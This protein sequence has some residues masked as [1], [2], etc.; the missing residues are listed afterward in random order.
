MYKTEA[1]LGL[2][3]NI[4]GIIAIALMLIVGL[5]IGVIIGGLAATAAEYGVDASQ[6]TMDATASASIG[7]VILGLVLAIAS[8]VFGFIG[9]S[10]L[11]KEDKKGGI[12]LIIAG[13]LGVVSLFTGGW[14]GIAMIVLYLIGGIMAV[15]KK[16]APMAPPM[17]PPAA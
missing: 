15:T 13:G 6:V 12:F 9:T 17:A 5:V 16:A 14:Y 10:K 8:V 2:V 11:K 4:L 3:G 1:T 7:L